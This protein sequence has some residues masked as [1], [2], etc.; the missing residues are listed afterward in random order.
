MSNEETHTTQ[1]VAGHTEESGGIAAGAK[2]LGLNGASLAAQIINFLILWFLLQRFVYRPLVGL[3]EKRRETIEQSVKQAEE[4]DKRFTDFQTEHQQR[5]NESKEEAAA[6]IEKA[7]KAAEDL[8]QE[9][10]TETQAESERLLG[11]TYEE[12]ERQKEQMMA[13]LR[14]EVG[15]LVVSATSKILNKEIDPETQQRLIK[16]ALA[17]VKE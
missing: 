11:R 7:K 2:S 5:M 3:L 6:I 12:I 4:M 15:T 1:E 17:E 9:T 14:Q 16:E 10:L 13:E 8:R